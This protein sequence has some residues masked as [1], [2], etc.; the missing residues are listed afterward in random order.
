MVKSA[1]LSCHNVSVQSHYPFLTSQQLGI[2]CQRGVFCFVAPFTVI[3][4]VVGANPFGAKVSETDCMCTSQNCISIS[5]IHKQIKAIK[6][7]EKESKNFFTVTTFGRLP[8]S[9]I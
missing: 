2:G 7:S 4:T 5:F 3:K 1:N 8:G 9:K 6:M